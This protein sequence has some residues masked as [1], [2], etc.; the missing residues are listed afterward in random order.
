M[1]EVHGKRRSSWDNSVLQGQTRSF[2]IKLV[3]QT[4]FLGKRQ[5]VLS[6]VGW[7][8]VDH[9]VDLTVYSD[10]GCFVF[11]NALT[12]VIAFIEA[13]PRVLLALLYEQGKA[14]GGSGAPPG[15][16]GSSA[17]GTQVVGPVE[18]Q[19]DLEWFSPCSDYIPPACWVC[20]FSGPEF[21]N[22]QPQGAWR[23]FLLLPPH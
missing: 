15:C 8:I 21:V 6:V 13:G 12:Y 18:V 17:L 9:K 2:S 19:S 11:A 16:M 3:L 23:G 10:W 22:V 5:Q 20:I 7:W 1:Q 14:R 4:S